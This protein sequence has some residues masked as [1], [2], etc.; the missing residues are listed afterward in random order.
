MGETE[1][2]TGGSL[3]GGIRYCFDFLLQC[4]SAM[5]DC[6]I[7][8]LYFSFLLQLFCGVYLHL[9]T[10]MRGARGLGETEVITG[11]SLL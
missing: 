5:I 2:I 6:I 7:I 10:C 1:V 8:L 4:P 9:L 3:L 11:G